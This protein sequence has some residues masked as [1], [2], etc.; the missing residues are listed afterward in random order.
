M[1]Q[2]AA[3][4]ESLKQVT[5]DTLV[6][7]NLLPGDLHYGARASR[8]GPRPFATFTVG[9]VGTERTNS[10]GVK[11]G[12]YEVVLT[13]VV[14]ESAS[15]TGRI[16]KLFHRF[17]DRLTSLPNLDPAEAR[18]VM[19][20]PGETPSE[21]GPAEDEDLGRDVIL[22]IT[23]WIVKLREKQVALE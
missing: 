19:I 13:V 12:V 4:A 16:L 9:R 10:S 11:I 3:I 2:S 6:I 21:I 5:V 14:D 23:S 20:L 18:L 8:I 15:L 22:G 1:P 17:W 7:R